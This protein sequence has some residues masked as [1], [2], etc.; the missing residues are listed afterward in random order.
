MFQIFVSIFRVYLFNIKPFQNVEDD[1]FLKM[2]T[3][4]LWLDAVRHV[5]TYNIFW[6][7]TLVLS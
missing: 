3:Y 1:H 4:G 5:L 6:D 7:V 2:P